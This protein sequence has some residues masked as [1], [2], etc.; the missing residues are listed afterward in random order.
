LTAVRGRPPTRQR[1]LPQ[2]RSPDRG[3]GIG[4]APGSGEDQQEPL[5][6]RDARRSGW[7]P[8]AASAALGTRTPRTPR[9]ARTWRVP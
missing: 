9:T 3:D 4:R 1:V 2:R 5:A 7:L 6:D 8:K